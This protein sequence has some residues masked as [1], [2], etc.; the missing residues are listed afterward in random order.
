MPGQRISAQGPTSRLGAALLPVPAAIGQGY[1]SWGKVSGSPGTTWIPAPAPL[2][3]YDRS[4]VAVAIQGV[5]AGGMGAPSSDTPFWRPGIYYQPITRDRVINC[6]IISD[7]QMP[8][9]AL[10]PNGKPAVMA[11]KQPMLRQRQIG[12]PITLPNYR[13]VN[14]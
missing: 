2:P 12:W 11:R 7:N 1:Q 14:Q 10:P 3:G 8:V 4:G 6:A 13:W 9:P 5:G